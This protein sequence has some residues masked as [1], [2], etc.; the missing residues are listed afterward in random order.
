MISPADIFYIYI[1]ISFFQKRQSELIT[2]FLV[3]AL[4]ALYLPKW[5]WVEPPSRISDNW[6]IHD[7]TKPTSWQTP[8]SIP[9]MTSW[10]TPWLAPR[11]SPLPA[12]WLTPWPI[13]WLEDCIMCRQNAKGR[14]KCWNCATKCTNCAEMVFCQ[15]FAATTIRGHQVPGS[16]YFHQ[17]FCTFL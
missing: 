8:R 12:P 9:W 3:V 7:M 13:L 1:H 11:P 17:L 5:W 15:K 14:K 2:F 16:C 6:A 4:E 10:L